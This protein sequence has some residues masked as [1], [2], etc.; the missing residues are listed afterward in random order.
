MLQRLFL[1]L[2]N[3]GRETGMLNLLPLLLQ[4]PASP[5]DLKGLNVPTSLVHNPPSDSLIISLNRYGRPTGKLLRTRRTRPI[6]L[7]KSYQKFRTLIE[8]VKKVVNVANVRF[9]VV[10]SL[11]LRV[12]SK[13][14]LRLLTR[15]C[16]NFL[17]RNL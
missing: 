14:L 7:S 8:A 12:L 2:M 11:A 4:L 10:R 17:P 1:Q 6:E 13:A 16:L 15:Y 3:R 5:R 9:G